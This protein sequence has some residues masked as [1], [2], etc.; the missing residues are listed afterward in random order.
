MCMTD[1]L[2]SHTFYYPFTRHK[3]IKKSWSKTTHQTKQAWRVDDQRGFVQTVNLHLCPRVHELDIPVNHVGDQ[4]GVPET[5][6]DDE[7]RD[8]RPV[9]LQPHSNVK[10]QLQVRQE[11]L[12]VAWISN[13][14]FLNIAIH[15]IIE[16]YERVWIKILELG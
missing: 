16:V 1:W 3:Q 7:Q 12:Q 6:V 14:H 15:E 11:V 5:Y 2:V 13:L 10:Q 4:F 9:G 8:D